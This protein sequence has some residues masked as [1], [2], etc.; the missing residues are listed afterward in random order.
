VAKGGVINE[1]ASS[2]DHLKDIPKL[3]AVFH[4]TSRNMLAS[5]ISENMLA[6]ASA[7]ANMKAGVNQPFEVRFSE[8]ENAADLLDTPDQSL[9]PTSRQAKIRAFERRATVRALQKR[10]YTGMRLILWYGGTPF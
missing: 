6:C 1:D 4:V 9:S 7:R 10:V 8:A 5:T 3:D 2:G